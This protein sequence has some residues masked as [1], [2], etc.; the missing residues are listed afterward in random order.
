[1]PGG[2]IQIAITVATTSLIK[3]LKLLLNADI[4]NNFYLATYDSRD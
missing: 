4:M 3:E 1:M 2:E